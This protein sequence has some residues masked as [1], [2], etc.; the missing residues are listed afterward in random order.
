MPRIVVV[1]SANVDY[2]LALA[3]LPRPGETVSGGSL[4][5]NLG[6]K[7]ANQATAAARG[8][9]EVA[10]IGCVGDDAAGREVRRS[11]ADEGVDVSG[12]ML[13]AEAATGAALILVGADGQNMIGVAPGANH[14]L[15][16]EAMAVHA[17]AIR[18]ADVVLCQ[19]ETPLA[20]VRWVLAEA[21]THGV[22]T[23]LDPAPV[24]PLDDELLGLVNYL[25]P[26]AGEAGALAGL[27][28][29]D[30]ASARAAARRLCARGVS[31]A[32]VTLGGAGCLAA[33]EEAAVHFP[34]FP[35]DAVD[36]TAAGDAFSG[37]L[38]VGLA[39]GGTLEQAIPLA[40]AA[41]ALTC[42]RRGAQDALPR[43]P[44]V[45]RFLA[46]RRQGAG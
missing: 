44:E 1:G 45:E 35:V 5:V 40:S 33:R 24:Q 19:L 12:L 29:S 37:V 2:A 18:T 11:L 31:T 13:T 21:R 36:T 3:R 6:G 42:M 25:T 43:R 26:N 27:E 14:R 8:G 15:R 9:G 38:A 32:V 41:A 10:L 4:L 46:S 23:V 28:V 20:V 30:L 17:P 22:T 7:G 39:A 34:A 16:V